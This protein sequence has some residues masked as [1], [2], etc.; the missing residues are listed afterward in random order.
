M[1]D[2]T[3][4]PWRFDDLA[5]LVTI[6][7]VDA[8][9]DSSPT[10]CVVGDGDTDYSLDASAIELEANVNLIAAAPGLLA[11]CAEALDWLS[12]TPETRQVFMAKAELKAAILKAQGGAA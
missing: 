1:S 3:K 12:G 11:A 10:V 2:H 7:T 5:P 6:Y 9:T 8:A 4:G